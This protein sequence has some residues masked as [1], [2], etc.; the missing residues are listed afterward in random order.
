[1]AQHCT[2]P[3]RGNIEATPAGGRP[4]S[5]MKGVVVTPAGRP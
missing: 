2:V 3:S 1:V 5:T 4:T